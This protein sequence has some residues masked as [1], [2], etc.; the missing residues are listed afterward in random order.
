VGEHPIQVFS[1]KVMVI[2]MCI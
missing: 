1:N 2:N